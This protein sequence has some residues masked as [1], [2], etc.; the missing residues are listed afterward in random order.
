MEKFFTIAIL[1][2]GL[3]VAAVDAKLSKQSLLRQTV[4]EGYDNL[5]KPDETITVKFGV[6]LLN[7]EACPHKQVSQLTV[8]DKD[9]SYQHHLREILFN[10]SNFDLSDHYLLWVRVSLDFLSPSICI[11]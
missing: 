1:I 6:T 11:I 3:V 9:L 8:K 5:V 7:L 4:F 2:A 10:I